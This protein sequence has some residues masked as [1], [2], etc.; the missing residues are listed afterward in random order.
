MQYVLSGLPWAAQTVRPTLGST[1]CQAYLGQRKLSGLPWAAQTVRPTLGQTNCQAYLGLHKISGLPWIAQTVRPTL[2]CTN[3]QAY[4]E[5]H[6]LSGLPWAARTFRPTL[7]RTYFSC[8]KVLPLSINGQWQRDFILFLKHYI[9]LRKQRVKYQAA[10]SLPSFAN[11]SSCNARSGETIPLLT[12]NQAVQYGEPVC[13][14]GAREGG[15]RGLR[16]QGPH[17]CRRT[18]RTLCRYV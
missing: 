10:C 8:L 16:Q 4:L 18:L 15:L 5:P 2:G 11:N 17:E 12:R 7:D 14:R 9:L 13:G 6:K 1:N 3:C